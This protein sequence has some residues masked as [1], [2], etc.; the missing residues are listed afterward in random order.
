M[1]EKVIKHAQNVL[2]HPLL[3]SLSF[4]RQVLKTPVRRR[5]KK[6]VEGF[7]LQATF[8]RTNE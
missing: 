3:P 2:S 7:E 5:T 8:P 6:N 4:R 1:Y